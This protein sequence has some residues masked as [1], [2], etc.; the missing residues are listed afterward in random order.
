MKCLFCGSER[1][2]T[3]RFR[4]ADMI[5]LLGFQYPIRCN[6]CKMRTYV[7]ILQALQIR[8]VH[9]LTRKRHTALQR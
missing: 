1:L 2:R 8:R 5:R 3:S 6:D 7:G 9:K 4:A